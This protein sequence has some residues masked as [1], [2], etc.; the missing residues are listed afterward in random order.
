MHKISKIIIFSIVG[1]ITYFIGVIIIDMHFSSWEKCKQYL[2]I[3]KDTTQPKLW[4][5]R[6]W[7]VCG[8]YTKRRDIYNAFIYYD[9]NSFYPVLV[10]EFKD[11]KNIDL[12]KIVFNKIVDIDLENIGFGETL[13][14]QSS[15]PVKVK[16]GFALHKDL[17]I[18]LDD[19][20]KIDGTFSGANYKGFWGT[21]NK[22][23]F[24][25]AK[26]EDQIIFDYSYQPYKTSFSPSVFLLYKGHQSFYVIII[27][28]KQAFKDASIIN[29]LNLQ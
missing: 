21:I 2:W 7:F 12:N 10:W 25:N 27:N 6:G 22:M 1:F 20:S 26:G 28:S 4:D 8:S 5:P 23:S 11:L 9:N 19:F 18:N 15:R 3:F 16:Y 17:K 13:D 14:T 29:I 24:S